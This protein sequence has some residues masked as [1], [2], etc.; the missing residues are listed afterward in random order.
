MNYFFFWSDFSL[1]IFFSLSGNSTL[2]QTPKVPKDYVAQMIL[3]T[4]Q[5]GL[6][7]QASL[8]CGDNPL[9]KKVFMEGK[10]SFEKGKLVFNCGIPKVL[11]R[12]KS[13]ERGEDRFDSRKTSNFESKTKP[14]VT[15]LL[16][17][18]LLVPVQGFFWPIVPYFR[19]TVSDLRPV[20]C[21]IWKSLKK[22]NFSCSTLDPS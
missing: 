14:K 22:K 6:V 3:I 9:R 17:Q 20:G 15:L 1:F 11:K 18:G 5:E 12:L 21:R 19:K 16:N 8:Q 7:S 10:F 13:V 4:I 2:S